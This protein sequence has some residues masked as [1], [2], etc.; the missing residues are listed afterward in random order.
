MMRTL[1]VISCIVLVLAVFLTSAGIRV[2]A[3]STEKPTSP[4]AHA[5]IE[6]FGKQVDPN[7]EFLDLSGVPLEHTAQVEEIL[8]LFPNLKQVDMCQCGISDEEMDALN[9]RY[10]DIQFVWEVTVCKYYQIRTDAT[11]F[12]PF[13]LHIP[14]G[15]QVDF[16]N[17]KYCSQMELLD[18]G[19][20]TVE[21]ISFIKNMPK[22]K[23]LLLCDNSLE[24]ISVIGSCTSLQY[25]EL[26]ANPIDDFAPLTNLTNLVDLNISFTPFTKGFGSDYAFTGEFGDITPLFQMTWLDRLWM[27]SSRLPQEEQEAL[28]KALPHTVIKF[29]SSSST[30]KGWRHSPHYYAGRDMVDGVYMI[31]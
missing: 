3:T 29:E 19:H 13:Q 8:S 15:G 22:L 30:D 18:F 4:Q 9:K 10:Q 12:M 5:T 20:Y 7:S 1:K 2:G 31:E 21:D 17:L 11:H 23:Y 27:S 25:L 6:V 16:S 28:S 14:K 24:D 26:F